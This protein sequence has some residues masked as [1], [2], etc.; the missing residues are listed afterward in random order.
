MRNE[1]NARIFFED[2]VYIFKYKCLKGHDYDFCSYDLL[3]G[4]ITRLM[5]LKVTHFKMDY[6]FLISRLNIRV[7]IDYI[8]I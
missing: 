6:S 2:N 3:S 1:Y 4:I 7:I 5:I 8:Y